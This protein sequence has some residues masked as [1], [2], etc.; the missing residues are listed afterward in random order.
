[1]NKYI[2]PTLLI[3]VSLL[4]GCFNSDAEKG[5]LQGKVLITPT[6]SVGTLACSFYD[7]RKI[8]IYDKSG[9]DLIYTVDIECNADEQYARYRVELEPGLYMVDIN[10]ISIDYSSDVPKIVEIISGVT[11]RLDINIDTGIRWY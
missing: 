2:L 11:K 7:I 6:S 5:F 1:M 10:Y 8:M 3:L 9:E 4:I